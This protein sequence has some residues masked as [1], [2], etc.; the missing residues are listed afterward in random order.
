MELHPGRLNEP[1]TASIFQVAPSILG[2]PTTSPGSPPPA[3][4]YRIGGVTS[5]RLGNVLCCTFG[6]SK[7]DL[8]L[9]NICW[10]LYP[11]KNALGDVQLR[12]LP[13]P[14]YS[15]SQAHVHEKKD[16]ECY[17]RSTIA[18]YHLIRRR[19]LAN[20]GAHQCS[21]WCSPQDPWTLVSPQLHGAVAKSAKSKSGTHHLHHL[22]DLVFLPHI[23]RRLQ[24][25]GMQE[26][27][28]HEKIT[29]KYL[30]ECSHCYT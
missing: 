6:K 12:H 15:T 24:I 19:T 14:E 8:M 3:R 25:F 13:T 20:Q 26:T 27:P 23:L 21:P 5:Y 4:R 17:A 7:H 9:L 1:S 16:S 28:Q 30:V 29:A 10:R 18:K 22:L 11:L 2:S